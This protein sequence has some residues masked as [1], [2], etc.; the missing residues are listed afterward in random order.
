MA[1]RALSIAR[2]FFACQNRIRLKYFSASAVVP[3]ERSNMLLRPEHYQSAASRPA[4]FAQ[5]AMLVDT[6]RATMIVRDWRI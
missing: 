3:I 4:S 2:G 5:N 1:T 6:Q